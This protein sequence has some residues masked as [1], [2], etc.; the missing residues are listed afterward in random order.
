[1]FARSM[2]DHGLGGEARR[3]D[4]EV[5]VGGRGQAE[6]LEVCARVREGQDAVRGGGWKWRFGKLLSPRVWW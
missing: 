1:M 5:L 2:G 4:P 3:T 6:G